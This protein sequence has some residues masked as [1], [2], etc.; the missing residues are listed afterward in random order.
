MTAKE[1]VCPQTMEHVAA[2]VPEEG[3]V[4]ALPGE[5]GVQGWAGCH[6]ASL[7]LGSLLKESTYFNPGTTRDRLIY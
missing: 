5:E 3:A 7:P 2:E 4:T 6:P 1:M